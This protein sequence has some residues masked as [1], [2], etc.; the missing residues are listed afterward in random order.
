MAAE[1]AGGRAKKV[2]LNLYQRFRSASERGLECGK[3][4]IFSKNVVVAA[5]PPCDWPD[6]SIDAGVGAP[7]AFLMR[8][9]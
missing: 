8:V 5:R 6:A 2:K 1:T 7:D 3:P 4:R 9:R